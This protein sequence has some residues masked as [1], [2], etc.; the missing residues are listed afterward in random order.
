MSIKSRTIPGTTLVGVTRGGGHETIEWARNG[1]LLLQR[2]YT[3]YGPGFGTDQSNYPGQPLYQSAPDLLV[4]TADSESTVRSNGTTAAANSHPSSPSVNLLVSAGELA[5]DGLP[6]VSDFTRWERSCRAIISQAAGN[7]VAVQFA[8]LPLLWEIQAW[9]RQVRDADEIMR[10][11]K[12]HKS[13]RVIRVGYSFPNDDRTVSTTAGKV[14]I[15][16]SNGSSVGN[17][18][19]TAITQKVRSKTWFE[20]KYLNFTPIS[21]DQLDKSSEYAMKARYLLGLDL[22]PVTLWELA[23]WSWAVD[24]VTNYGD[25]L[26]SVSNSLS[27]G[28][29]MYDAFV[30]HHYR[31]E[32]TAIALTPHIFTY[33]YKWKIPVV[34]PTSAKRVSEVKKRFPSVPYFG[35]GSPGEL[36]ARQISILA[37]LGISRG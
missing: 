18:A 35:F 16:W 24:W 11:A 20:A 37:A 4:G 19:Q 23:P 1:P 7:W 36:T 21:A 3:R 33:R 9:L 27:D 22:T 17:P 34:T 2:E 29:V 14:A 30:M 25:V 10:E 8:W 15:S 26:D 31:R 32:S 5:K 12:S 28:M 6:R 13:S